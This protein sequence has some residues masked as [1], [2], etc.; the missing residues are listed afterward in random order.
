MLQ[1]HCFISNSEG[2]NRLSAIGS[3]RASAKRTIKTKEKTKRLGDLN[4]GSWQWFSIHQISSAGNLTGVWCRN[5]LG[6]TLIFCLYCKAKVWR[7]PSTLEKYPAPCYQQIFQGGNIIHPLDI[8]SKLQCEKT[9]I[10]GKHCIRNI[11]IRGVYGTGQTNGGALN[12][13]FESI[14]TGWYSGWKAFC[15]STLSNC[16]IRLIVYGF[17]ESKYTVWRSKMCSMVCW[18]LFG[19]LLYV[20]KSLPQL[21]FTADVLVSPLTYPPNKS[22]HLSKGCCK[23]LYTIERK[24]HSTRTCCKPLKAPWVMWQWKVLKVAIIEYFIKL[25]FK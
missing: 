16:Q 15:S 25:T 12:I 24:H 2:G 5:G 20:H 1:F 8:H 14:N 21:V 6:L 11:Q 9:H 17:V 3:L 7:L 22:K 10:F 13:P 18:W 19:T 4:H 23:T